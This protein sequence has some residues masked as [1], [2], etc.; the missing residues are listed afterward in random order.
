MMASEGCTCSTISGTRSVATA[1]GSDVTIAG[2][3]NSNVFGG[4][5]NDDGFAS[6]TESLSAVVPEPSSLMLGSIAGL[7]FLTLNP[8]DK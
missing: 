5:L 2:L 3:S 8:A 7:A 1:S 4:Q 6:F